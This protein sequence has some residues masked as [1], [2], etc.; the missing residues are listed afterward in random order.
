RC[1]HGPP[2]REEC[3]G[4][5]ARR[6]KPFRH[7]T[8]YRHATG[9]EEKVGQARPFCAFRRYE[10]DEVDESCHHQ[11]HTVPTPEDEPRNQGRG[12]GSRSARD[13]RGGEEAA[14]GENGAPAASPPRDGG[15]PAKA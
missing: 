5:P 9:D 13:H 14:R 7:V 3:R 8:E 11:G 12:Y 2:L 4:Q 10:K 1:G 15:P 6:V